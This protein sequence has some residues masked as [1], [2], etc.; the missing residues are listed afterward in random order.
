MVDCTHA[1]TTAVDAAAAAA[2]DDAECSNGT[3]S[4]SAENILSDERA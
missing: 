2:V 3:L 1:G 4:A